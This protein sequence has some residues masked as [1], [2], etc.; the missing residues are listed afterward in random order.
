MTRD[1]FMLL[2][3]TG[4]RR[5]VAASLTWSNVNMTRRTFK[6]FDKNGKWFELPMTVYLFEMFQRRRASGSQYVFPAHGGG[7]GYISQTAIGVDLGR[8]SYVTLHTTRKTFASIAA[9]ILPYGIV[10]RLMNHSDGKDVRGLNL[11]AVC[12]PR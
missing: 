6:V 12:D 2:M 3:L 11:T 4:L 10:K 8:A 1:Y 7:S 5:T 9:Q